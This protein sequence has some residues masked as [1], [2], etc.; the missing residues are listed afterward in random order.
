[1]LRRR[2]ERADALRG[3][4]RIAEYARLDEALVRRA[5]PFAAYGAFTI[6]EYFSPRVGCKLFQSTY[7]FVDLGALCVRAG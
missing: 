1:M 7:H 4:P 2:I 6:P 3:R 5:V